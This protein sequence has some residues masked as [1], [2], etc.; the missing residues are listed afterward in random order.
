MSESTAP[1]S[2]RWSWPKRLLVAGLALV[3]L[4]VGAGVA[5]LVAIW[6]R[7]NLV[8]QAQLAALR[9]DPMASAGWEGIDQ[10]A[11]A[12]SDPYASKPAQPSYTRCLATTMPAREAMRLISA[13][14][15]DIGWQ[16]HDNLI[17][18][19]SWVAS[20]EVDGT[21]RFLILTTDLV[22]CS[23]EAGAVVRLTLTY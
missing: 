10:V 11:V 22:S 16:P 20:R 18:D 23:D 21:R 14:A 15:E 8:A 6:Y 7:P 1:V 5:L 19:S 2:K 17:S 9:A 4:V 13:S 3:V 12:E